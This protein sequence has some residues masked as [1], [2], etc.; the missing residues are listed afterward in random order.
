MIVSFYDFDGTLM[1]S[2]EPSIGKKYWK[3]VVGSDYPYEGWWGRPESLSLDV[4]DIKPFPNIVREYERQMND[5]NTTLVLLTSRIT[6]LKP[7]LIEILD[8]N[9][10][11]FDDYLLKD[12]NKTKSERVREYLNT[13]N[14]DIDYINLYD[15]R[16]KE[17]EDFKRLSDLPFDVNIYRVGRGNIIEKI[18]V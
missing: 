14:A 2:P 12:D 3:D 5:R 1:D 6:K 16:D 11:Y 13:L 18:V 7:Q 9:N 8:F 10:I 15:D 17:I 4:F